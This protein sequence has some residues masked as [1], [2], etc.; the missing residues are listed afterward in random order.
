[1][2]N[3]FVSI[4]LDLLLMGRKILICFLY[5]V[6]S[7]LH[8]IS[9]ESQILVAGAFASLTNKTANSDSTSTSKEEKEEKEY[10]W[11]QDHGDPM[12]IYSINDERDD[13]KDR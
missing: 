1:M 2:K 13:D 10:W 7:F 5:E 11:Y 4:I 9:K 12:H 3:E 6:M 8:S